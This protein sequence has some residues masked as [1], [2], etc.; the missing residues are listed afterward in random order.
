M[1]V[2]TVDEMRAIEQASVRLGVPLDR[3][4]QNA[5]KAVAEE[6]ERRFGEVEG[7]LLF[8]IGPGNNGRDALIAADLLRQKGRPVRAYLAPKVGSEDV[9]KRLKE[10]GARIH[11][12]SS[13]GDLEVL[14]QWIR[15]AVVVVDGLLGI[16]IRGTVR[17]PMAGI[18][19]VAAEE[20]KLRQVPVVAVDLPSGIDADTG[21]IAGCALPASYTVSLGCVKAGLLQFPAADYVGHLVP[22][23]IGLP[24]ESYATVRTELLD[25][26]VAA[27]LV[28]HRPLN[29]HK[30]T[31]GRVLVVGGSRNFVGAPYLAAA[32]AARAGCGLVTLAVPEWQRGILAT[33]LPEATYLPL[34]DSDEVVAAEADAQA[35]SELLPDCTALAVGPGLGQ[36][37]GQLRLVMGVLEAARPLEGIGVVVDADGL[38]ALADV[39]ASSAV[40]ELPWWERIGPG[41]VLTPHPGEMSR[42]M[43]VPIAEVN[44][45]RWGIAS[46]AA[47]LWR[48]VVVLKGAFT[49]VA[50]PEGS[51]WISP[52]A[53]PALASAGTGDVLTG[54]IAGLMAQGASSV[55]AACSG[56][57]LHAAAA[58]EVL[59]CQGTD[60]LLAGDLLPAIPVAIAGLPPSRSGHRP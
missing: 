37:P 33:L 40:G 45:D 17:E 29:A 20:T 26:E 49:V 41:H 44:Q 23:G 9:L 50:E 19:K 57:F 32:A 18:I 47:A 21:Q 7:P 53:M 24:P 43:R 39:A 4:Q 54:M 56:V 1:K 22:V 5:A 2:V 14:R 30:G 60:R 46:R 35:V 25:A 3:L 13:T 34:L 31:F 48:Q 51:R 55:G 11:G 59:E 12:Y 27:G 42:L 10:G 36:G 38:N 28:P 16:G 6:I 58:S 8:L 15:D 52:F